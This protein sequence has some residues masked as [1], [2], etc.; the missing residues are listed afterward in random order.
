[1]DNKYLQKQI[2]KSL[3]R[4][5]GFTNELKQI[6][7]ETKRKRRKE[8]TKSEWMKKKREKKE[9][10][11]M[12]G[13][14]RYLEVPPPFLSTV[15]SDAMQW[16]SFASSKFVSLLIF[17]MFSMCFCVIIFFYLIE[18]VIVM[19]RPPLFIVFFSFHPL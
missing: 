13:I 15:S 14:K 1:M 12:K 18:C 11:E 5:Q 3:T 4:G 6:K 17:C 7:H 10:N 19:L 2:S 16:V 8:G 9:R